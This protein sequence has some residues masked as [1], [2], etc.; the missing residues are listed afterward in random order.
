MEESLESIL[1]RYRS[2][3]SALDRYNAANFPHKSKVVVDCPQYRGPGVVLRESSCPP[4]KVSVMLENGNIWHYP[5]QC[6]KR[7]EGKV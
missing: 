6:V 4:T 7:V 2:A 1:Y 3:E 5:I